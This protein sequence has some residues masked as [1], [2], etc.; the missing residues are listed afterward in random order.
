[1]DTCNEAIWEAGKQAFSLEAQALEAAS[2]ALSAA[3]FLRAVDVLA[4]AARIGASGCG[5]SGIACQHFA[6][7]MCCIERPA[8]SFR[9]RKPYMERRDFCKRAT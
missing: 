7:L 9:Q 4:R 1:M 3:D 6:H 5:H 2:E 8:R